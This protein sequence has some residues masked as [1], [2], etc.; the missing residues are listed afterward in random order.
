MIDERFVK[1]GEFAK[2]WHPELVNIYGNEDSFCIIGNSNIGAFVEIGPGVVIGD[3][4]SIG[5]FCFI[6]SGITIEDGC[7]IGPG[8]LFTNDKYPPSHKAE[9]RKTVVKKNARIGAKAVI[10]PGITIG[11]RS[12]IGMGSVVTKDVPEGSIVMGNPAKIRLKKI[13]KED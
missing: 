8:V 7:F 3:N 10:A 9:W 1:I 5:A 11:E 2:I 12:L 6:P 13:W 4:V